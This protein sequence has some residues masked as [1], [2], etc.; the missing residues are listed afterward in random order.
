[1]RGLFVLIYP[2][3]SRVPQREIAQKVSTLFFLHYDKA[4]SHNPERIMHNDTANN[5][6]TIHIGCLIKA[7]LT[8]QGRSITWLA[9]QVGYTRENLY[10]IMRR[11]WIYTDLLFKICDALDYDFFKVCSDWRNSKNSV[12]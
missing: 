11:E 2:I 6:N 1:M 3:G 5:H 12:N 8:R 4:L 9:N 7:E 10:K